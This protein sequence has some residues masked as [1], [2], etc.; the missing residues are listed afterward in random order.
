VI[1]ARENGWQEVAFLGGIIRHVIETGSY[2]HDY[3]V[4]YTDASTIIDEKFRDTE[5]LEGVFSGFDPAT[6]MYDWSSWMYE[7]GEVGSAAGVRE[8]ST[9]SFSERMTC[10]GM[11]MDEVNR[12][13][14][15]QHPRCVF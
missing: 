9:E 5:D 14:S 6:G 11:T 2:F 3:V 1:E 15:L 13:E 10:A 8:H 4:N 12:D 7:G